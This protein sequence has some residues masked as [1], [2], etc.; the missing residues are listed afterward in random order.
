MCMM[1][2]RSENSICKR[3]ITQRSKEREKD[4]I[5]RRDIQI[6]VAA[7]SYSRTPRT[8]AA[9]HPT[10]NLLPGPARWPISIL[11]LGTGASRIWRK[12]YFRQ[13]AA[14]PTN[15]RTRAGESGRG[16]Y[17]VFCFCFFSESSLVWLVFFSI[18]VFSIL[19]IFFKFQQISILGKF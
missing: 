11:V 4:E 13:A 12:T 8:T 1:L 14:R 16:P 18:F 15:A 17:K 3:W 7:A 5:F 6:L 10:P 2:S 19:N 9:I